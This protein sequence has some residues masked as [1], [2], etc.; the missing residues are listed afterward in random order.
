VV[1][2]GNGF[3]ENSGVAL[4]KVILFLFPDSLSCPVTFFFLFLPRKVAVQSEG[5]IKTQEHPGPITTVSSA[6]SALGNHRGLISLGTA[7][8]VPGCVP[9]SSVSLGRG[10]YLRHSPPSVECRRHPWPWLILTQLLIALCLIGLPSLRRKE[11]G[12]DTQ[13]AITFGTHYFYWDSSGNY[14]SEPS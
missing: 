4:P 9:R 7:A 2:S 14:G 3:I 10:S 11:A 8:A 1:F 12:A 5:L 6:A 13:T